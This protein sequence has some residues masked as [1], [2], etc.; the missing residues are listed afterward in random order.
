VG[1]AGAH[2]GSNLRHLD[3]IERL[4]R[5]ALLDAQS[6]GREKRN[7]RAC[8]TDLGTGLSVVAVAN[9]VMAD[10]GSF[11]LVLGKIGGQ[12]LSES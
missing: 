1:C 2:L 10:V 4:S 6:A 12:L 8:P 5:F 7:S 3:G 9:G 11:D